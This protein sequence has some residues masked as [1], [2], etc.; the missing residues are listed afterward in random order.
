MN[1]NQI[2]KKSEKSYDELQLSYFY[3]MYICGLIIWLKSD[4]IIIG[5][6]LGNNRLL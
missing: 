2:A 3:Y 4:N 1:F 5:L 6:F